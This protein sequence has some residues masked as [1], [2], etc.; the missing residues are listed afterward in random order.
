MAAL[1]MSLGFVGLVLTYLIAAA[2][3]HQ[4]GLFV[5]AC[6]LVWGPIFLFIAWAT[7]RALRDRGPRPFKNQRP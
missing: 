5:V 6:L 2:E 7:R 4:L 3:V 1:V